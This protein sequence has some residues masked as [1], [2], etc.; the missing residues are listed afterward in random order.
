MLAASKGN[1]VLCD[2]LINNGA[3][4][5]LLDINGSFFSFLLLLINTKKNSLST[6]LAATDQK[7]QN[8]QLEIISTLLHQMGILPPTAPP[9]ESLCRKTGN[10]IGGWVFFRFDHVICGGPKYANFLASGRGMSI[11]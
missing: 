10:Q 8:A 4:V 5:T 6:M 7:Q 9:G 11:D 3:D 2:Y 1:T